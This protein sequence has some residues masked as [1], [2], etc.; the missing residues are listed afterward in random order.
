MFARTKLSSYPFFCQ[1]AVCRF[2]LPCS[3][4]I[5]RSTGIRPIFKSGPIVKKKVSTHSIIFY[6][7]VLEHRIVRRGL[8]PRGLADASPFADD[9]PGVRRSCPPASSRAPFLSAGKRG[10][11]FAGS[12][13]RPSDRYSSMRNSQ[14]HQNSSGC[15]SGGQATQRVL[16]RGS[17]A[18]AKWLY[19]STPV[20][21]QG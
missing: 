15:A 18:E 20:V 4:R 14:A 9:R 6:L 2:S 19:S 5:V 11:G 8:Y 16:I 1:C 12:M 3:G 21:L 10:S 13:P 7:P 17:T